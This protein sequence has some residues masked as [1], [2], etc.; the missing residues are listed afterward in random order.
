MSSDLPIQHTPTGRSG[1]G[2]LWHGFAS[3]LVGLR[4]T[5]GKLFVPKV[6][7]KYPMEKLQMTAAY[8]SAIA[9]VRFD[10]IDTHDCIAC[11]ACQL[12][13][14]S[15]CIELSGEKMPNSK[16]KRVTSFEVDFTTCSLCGLC[17]AVCPTD[18][19]RYSDGYDHAGPNRH[20]THD[21]LQ[22]FDDPPMDV[23]AAKLDERA[24]KQRAARAA[25]RGD[26]PAKTKAAP[27]AK[28]PAAKAPAAEAPTAKAL[29]AK[30]P[31]TTAPA[32]TPDA[33]PTADTPD[34]GGG[35]A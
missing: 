22:P 26:H 32:A 27:A 23:L 8:R 25:A 29:A 18:T 19:L 35:D 28:A 10:D 33:A 17:L 24:K 4:V 20:W 12:I 1:A 31:A 15:H 34:D 13:C 21:L 9:L 11:S 2:A 30:A 16:K 5:L 7:L 6:T 14:P 3:A